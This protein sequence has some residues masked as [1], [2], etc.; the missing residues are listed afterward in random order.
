MSNESFPQVTTLKKLRVAVLKTV[1]QLTPGQLNK[2]PDG[3]N[4]NI[5]W[6]V[7]H[8]IASQQN[9]CYIKA[10]QEALVPESFIQAYKP[11]SK[12]EKE[13]SAAEIEDIKALLLSTTT[14]LENDLKAHHFDQYTPWVNSM[15]LELNNINDIIN[16]LP[17][18]ESMHLGYILALKRLI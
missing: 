17:L 3:F 6:N 14:E 12:P 15:G 1:E 4:N 18:H 5:I 13:V 8:L 7:A 9:L 10:G 11:G 16:Y 2:V